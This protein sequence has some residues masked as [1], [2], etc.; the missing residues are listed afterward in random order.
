MVLTAF[1]DRHVDGFS[2]KTMEVTGRGSYFDDGE[3]VVTFGAP[4]E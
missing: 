4:L 1:D 3:D 2:A